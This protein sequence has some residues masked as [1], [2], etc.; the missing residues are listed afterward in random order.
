[1]PIDNFRINKR[2]DLILVIFCVIILF[3]SFFMQIASCNKNGTS[4]LQVRKLMSIDDYDNEDNVDYDN[5]DNDYDYPPS[6][7]NSIFGSYAQRI[8]ERLSETVNGGVSDS[9]SRHSKQKKLMQRINQNQ[10]SKKKNFLQKIFSSNNFSTDLMNPF[11]FRRNHL[12]HNKNSNNRHSR[13]GKEKTS[14]F[15]VVTVDGKGTNVFSIHFFFD[16]I[17]KS[18]NSKNQ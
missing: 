13:N 11:S 4:K 9:H 8:S 14:L 17:K 7:F 12:N 15:L 6:F 5:N 10:E 2:S 1:M 3:N 16:N 18:Q